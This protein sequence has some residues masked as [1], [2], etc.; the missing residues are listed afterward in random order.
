MLDESVFFGINPSGGH[1]PFTYT[2][3]D[4]SGSLI[5]LA[6]GELNDMLDFLEHKKSAFVAV[7]APMHPNQGLVRDSFKLQGEDQGTMRGLDLRL[8]E[9]ELHKIGIS[10]QSTPSRPE[11]CP[12]WIQM[13]FMIYD[14]LRKRNYGLYPL[15]DH[16]NFFECGPG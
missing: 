4:S 16:P 7:N 14:E 9:H 8:A 10:V 5:I 6:Q 1:F 11:F 12:P 13:G 15:K 3:L 2:A